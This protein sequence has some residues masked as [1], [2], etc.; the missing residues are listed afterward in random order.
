MTACRAGTIMPEKA[1]AKLKSD[2]WAI[3][4]TTGFKSKGGLFFK[5]LLG[6]MEEDEPLPADWRAEMTP[7]MKREAI[8]QTV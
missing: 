7:E 1:A 2:G 5:G 8:L 6:V 3:F 4:E